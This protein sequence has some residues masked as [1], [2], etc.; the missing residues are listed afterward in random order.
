MHELNR[1]AV[2]YGTSE[3]LEYLE[4]AFFMTFVF[5]SE[6]RCFCAAA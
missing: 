6:F 5:L 1:S 4:A 2:E 3:H